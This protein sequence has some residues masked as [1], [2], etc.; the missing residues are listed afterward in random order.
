MERFRLDC[1]TGNRKARVW[2]AVFDR[3]H[4]DREECSRHGRQEP[5][6][7]GHVPTPAK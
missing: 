2:K 4:G 7:A 6:R 5:G 1:S 3:L